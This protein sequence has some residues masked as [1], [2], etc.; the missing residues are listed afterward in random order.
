MLFTKIQSQKRIFSFVK[1]VPLVFCNHVCWTFFCWSSRFGSA[2]CTWYSNQAAE[3]RAFPNPLCLELTISGKLP[4]TEHFHSFR[5]FRPLSPAPRLI[6][7]SS[8]QLRPTTPL[9]QPTYSLLL[10]SGG[11]F[12]QKAEKAANLARSRL[13]PSSV[14]IV[15]GEQVGQACEANRKK[16]SDGGPEW[17][18]GTPLYVNAVWVN[19]SITAGGRLGLD[20]VRSLRQTKT[21]KDRQRQL[22]LVFAVCVKLPALEESFSKPLL[23]SYLKANQ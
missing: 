16:C 20:S 13:C 17:S 23:C 6:P 1:L 3:V 2:H 10:L 15:S 9:F 21:D 22:S 11:K 18:G 14:D 4:K 7:G 19:V 12:R 8:A 5:Q